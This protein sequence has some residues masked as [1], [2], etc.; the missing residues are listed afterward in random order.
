VGPPSCKFGWS[1][2]TFFMNVHSVGN[3]IIPSD[4][5][6]FQRGWNHQAVNS[7]D[8]EVVSFRIP[9]LYILANFRYPACV[10][11]LYSWRACIPM[12]KGFEVSNEPR[13]IW[14]ICLDHTRTS[15]YPSKWCLP[16]K[17]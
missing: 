1:F 11:L 2:G 16:H 15:K 8:T 13:W 10:C 14:A 17:S 12:S 6:I 3:F 9:Q 5:S 7:W 4:F